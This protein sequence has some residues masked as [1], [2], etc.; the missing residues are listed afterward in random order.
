MVNL[1]NR[2]EKD[3]DD[4][5]EYRRI[6]AARRLFAPLPFYAALAFFSHPRKN[7]QNEML[8]KMD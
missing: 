8:R 6:V 4:D 2:N 5:D 3:E 1:V 7:K